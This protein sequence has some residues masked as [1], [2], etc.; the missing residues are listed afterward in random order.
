MRFVFSPII[1]IWKRYWKSV[2]EIVFKVQGQVKELVNLIKIRF[3]Y[4][5][6]CFTLLHSP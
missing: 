6:F 1:N 2:M 3:V 4:D 5:K